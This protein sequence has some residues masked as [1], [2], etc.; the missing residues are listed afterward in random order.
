MIKKN[1]NEYI[2]E[3]NQVIVQ[4]ESLSLSEK[5]DC[6]KNLKK[7][8]H[9]TGVVGIEGARIEKKT[10]AFGDYSQNS[11]ISS[12]SSNIIQEP[13][14]PRK[15]IKTTG[16]SDLSK[17]SENLIRRISN[18]PSV[19]K[20]ELFNKAIREAGLKR[21]EELRKKNPIKD[22]IIDKE[23]NMA[24]KFLGGEIING[25]KNTRKLVWIRGKNRFSMNSEAPHGND[26]SNYTGNRRD[27]ILNVLESG[28]LFDLNEKFVVNY[29]EKHNFYKLYRLEKF[30]YFVLTNKTS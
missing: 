19:H 13:V 27:R 5:L 3:K 22:T 17:A 7:K 14:L 20:V 12:I 25:S 1:I 9:F 18:P 10:I 21:I 2:I 28:Y 6:L 11:N 16:V 30:L 4:K 8:K 26:S 24:A 15:K 23:L 29:I